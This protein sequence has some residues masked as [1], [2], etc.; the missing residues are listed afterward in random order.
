MRAPSTATHHGVSSKIKAGEAPTNPTSF[1]AITA[2]Q[3]GPD[4][5]IVTKM[6]PD[7]LGAPGQV[8]TSTRPIAAMALT[9]PVIGPLIKIIQNGIDKT[10]SERAIEMFSPMFTAIFKANVYVFFFYT[11]ALSYSFTDVKSLI[12]NY[13]TA[14]FLFYVFLWHTIRTCYVFCSFHKTTK[15]DQINYQC[16]TQFQILNFVTIVA[17]FSDF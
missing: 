11:N 15:R 17:T 13:L 2:L 1:R 16:Y 12:K 7:I 5:T 3:N 8:H 14:S 9:W 6:V 4:M 10:L